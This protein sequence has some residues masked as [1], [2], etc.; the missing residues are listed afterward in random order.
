MEP[1]TWWKVD[2][3]QPEKEFPDSMKTSTL[4]LLC[5]IISFTYL[6]VH[7]SLMKANFK[8]PAS[9]EDKI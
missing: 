6:S 8:F 7:Q 9:S 2:S 3:K 5:A 1:W 4:G